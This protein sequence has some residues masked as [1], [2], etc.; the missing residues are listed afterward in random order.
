MLCAQALAVVA[1]A[2]QGIPVRAALR[3]QYNADDVR[4]DL[5]VWAADQGHA[6]LDEAPSTLRIERRR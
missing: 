6:I 4:R 2:V 5:T 1:R 3:V